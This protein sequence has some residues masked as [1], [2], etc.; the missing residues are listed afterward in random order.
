MAERSRLRTRELAHRRGMTLVVVLGLL[1]ALLGL[2]LP[3]SVAVASTAVSF[4]PD[5]VLV[6]LEPGAST[7]REVVVDAGT[8]L[9]GV[10]LEATPSLAGAVELPA[11]ADGIFQAGTTV[12]QLGLRAPAD[13]KE[14]TSIAGTVQVRAGARTLAR[15]LRVQIRVVAED[16]DSRFG[17]ALL[18]PTQGDQVTGPVVLLGSAIGGRAPVSLDFLVDGEVVATAPT[19]D[20]DGLHRATWDSSTGTS[21]PRLLSVRASDARGAVVESDVTLVFVSNELVPGSVSAFVLSEDVAL[22]ELAGALAAAGLRPV[23][24]DHRVPTRGGFHSWVLPLET[25]V[26]YY[27]S[28]FEAEHGG[29]PSVFAFTVHGEADASMLGDLEGLVIEQGTFDADDVLAFD[30]DPSD[31]AAI[32]RVPEDVDGLDTAAAP[33]TLPSTAAA[34]MAETTDAEA[35]DPVDPEAAAAPA[36]VAAANVDAW[37]PDRGSISGDEGTR[38][39]RNW[40]W[41]LRGP[42]RVEVE[43]AVVEH[44]LTWDDHSTSSF[45][46]KRAFEHNLRLYN[47]ARRGIRPACNP[48]TERDFWVDR[49]WTS[50]DTSFPATARPY[51]DADKH[52]LLGVDASVSDGCD[53]ADLTVGVLVPREITDDVEHVIRVETNRGTR[54]TSPFAVIPQNSGI[55]C[56]PFLN[57]WCVGL[58]P[59][60][61]EWQPAIG[62]SA[63]ETLPGCFNWNWSGER[64]DHRE[65][66]QQDLPITFSEFP[67]RTE[68]TDQYLDWGVRF[69]GDDP[70]IVSDGA[71]PTSPVLAGQPIYGGNI[72]MRFVRPG[73]TTPT[74]VSTVAFDIGFIDDP[75]AVIVSWYASDGTLLGSR[76]VMELGLPR[77]EIVGE[78]IHRVYVDITPQER[79]GAAI[80][81][82]DFD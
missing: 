28:T 59:S 33:T 19:A 1:G 44:R 79:A 27:R 11:I 8:T 32:Q 9:E 49:S 39:V 77:F 66:G 55:Y 54:D 23:A 73:T 69:G 35:T 70:I 7:T 37:W 5:G 14:G 74:T 6:D 24:F 68:V 52:P 2:S 64:Y 56:G 21:G 22:A 50:W 78:G 3:G 17:A 42:Q 72:E 34:D 30:P 36:S 13:A 53:E 61:G 18:A 67:L 40:L 38:Q 81:N 26:A 60:Q 48:L 4:S 62:K 41:P 80:D 15:P 43:T 65:C 76:G 58:R 46:E 51:F 16:P 12:L 29:E 57:R 75:G 47:D 45:E 82:L 31:D 63:G 20:A 10:R 71:N 25:A